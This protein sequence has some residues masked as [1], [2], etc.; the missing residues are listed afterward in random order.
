MLGWRVTRGGK[1]EVAMKRIAA[2]AAAAAVISTLTAITQAT[3]QECVT[4]AKRAQAQ[5]CIRDCGKK[6]PKPEKSDREN[7]QACQDICIATCRV[8]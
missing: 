6:Y 1:I 4:A 8:P 3:A 7:R 2:L 5:A